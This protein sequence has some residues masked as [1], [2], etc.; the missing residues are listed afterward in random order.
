MPSS[1]QAGDRCTIP[2]PWLNP[3]KEGVINA[4][5]HTIET[6]KRI[7]ESGTTKIHYQPTGKAVNRSDIAAAEAGQGTN[8][9]K[10]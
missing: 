1:R 6:N 3:R 4:W 8:I 10:R 9:S 2:L 5:H 7:Y